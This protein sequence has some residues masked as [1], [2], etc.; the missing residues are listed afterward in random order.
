M[1]SILAQGTVLHLASLYTLVHSVPA[2]E[3]AASREIASLK[4]M[5]DHGSLKVCEGKLF[6]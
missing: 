2:S 6:A 4:P 5:F 3:E 1:K